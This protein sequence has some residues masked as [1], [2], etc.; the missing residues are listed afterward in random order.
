MSDNKGLEINLI[1][2]SNGFNTNDRPTDLFTF[3]SVLAGRSL[4]TLAEKLAPPS[5][6]SKLGPH[7]HVR[8]C[9]RM[10]FGRFSSNSSNL[11]G[12][13]QLVAKQGVSLHWDE[14]N[15]CIPLGLGRFCL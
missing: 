6:Q 7:F 13:I 15:L 11:V 2:W 14:K 12:K 10:S 1:I 8:F 5:N 3:L 9:V 4:A